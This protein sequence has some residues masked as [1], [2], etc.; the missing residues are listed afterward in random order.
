MKLANVQYSACI[1]FV[2]TVST[3]SPWHSSGCE[4][5]MQRQPHP[6]SKIDSRWNTSK[7]KYSSMLDPC[8]AH[9]SARFGILVQYPVS[10]DGEHLLYCTNLHLHA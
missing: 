4:G 5:A 8:V 2:E 7:L 3:S 6:T 9:G 1:T 10:S